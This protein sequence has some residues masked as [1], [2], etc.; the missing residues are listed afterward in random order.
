[1]FLQFGEHIDSLC[2]TRANPAVVRAVEEFR[3]LP[4]VGI[5]PLSTNGF[6]PGFHGDL[7]FD[8]LTL[9]PE[10][11][12]EGARVEALVR[13]GLN[14]PPV[15]LQAP[16]RPVMLWIYRVRENRQTVVG[17]RTLTAVQHY[18]IFS[19]GHLAYLG[20]PHFDVNRWDYSN[21]AY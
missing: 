2:R 6:V 18:T 1:M 3:Y 21:Y 8:T 5:I 4:P 10:V 16:D 19:S 11:F 14:Y 13:T 9:H 17:G 7:F 20:D 15:D 12:I